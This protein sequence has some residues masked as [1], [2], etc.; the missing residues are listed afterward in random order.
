MRISVAKVSVIVPV[1]NTQEYL[2]KCL[3]ALVNQTLE[4]IEIVIINDGSTDSSEEIIKKYIQNYPQK[5]V[6]FSK[7]NGGQATARNLGIKKCKGKYIGFADSDDCVDYSMFEKMYNLAEEKS[8]DMV[9][10]NFHFVQE[11]PKGLRNLKARG[12][13]REYKDKKD[14]FINPQV[15]PWNKL[16]KREAL[17]KSGIEFPEGLIYEDTAF[18]IKTISFVEKSAYLDEKLVYYYLHGNSTMNANKSHKVSDIFKVLQDILDFYE[19]NNLYDE[20]YEELEYFYV[21]ILLCSSLSRIGRVTDKKLKS[22]MLDET[23]EL[24][25]SKFPAYKKNKYFSGKIGLYIKF[26][27]R[28]NSRL[29]STILG[30]IMKG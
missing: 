3:D 22:K 15:S 9:E 28:K 29:I 16:Y 17:I 25:N 27:N 4:D 24:V 10:C 19:K 8:C 7:E 6:Y 2:E 12:N 21:K 11:T 30:K 20:F 18:Y 1:Y 14:M 23:F 13:V 5:I 26:V